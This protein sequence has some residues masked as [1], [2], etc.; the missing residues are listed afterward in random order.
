MTLR[1]PVRFVI[2]AA[3]RT[4][5]NFLCGLLN[6]HPDILCHHG[7]FNPAGIHYA[8]HQR[9]GDPY[10]GTVAERDR[11]PEAFLE[12][13]WRHGGGK[14]AVGFK[15]NLGENQAA[16]A[17]VLGD[18]GVRKILLARRH[19]IKTYVS[20]QIAEQSGQWESYT[21]TVFTPASP[22]RVDVAELVRQVE[23]NRRY[24]AD[25]ESNLL[26]SGQTWLNVHYE[27]LDSSTAGGD[28]HQVLEFLGL[29]LPAE[30]GSRL[31]AGSVKRNPDDLRALIAN[32]EE[33]KLE[34][35]GTELECELDTDPSQPVFS[36]SEIPNV[37]SVSHDR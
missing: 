2:F 1:T 15:F 35:A 11:A 32:F 26:S 5:S 16:V 4:G 9:E 21:G 34:L 19:R 23:R 36:L 31:T 20:E 12:R 29:G 8:L 33:L 37:R 22:I 18:P 14:S 10:L 28:L 13:V 25:L 27:S 6:S 24:Y 30:D 7:L 3:P 17:A